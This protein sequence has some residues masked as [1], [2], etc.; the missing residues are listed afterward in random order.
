[1]EAAVEHGLE[2]LG[3]MAESASI[4]PEDLRSVATRLTDPERDHLVV[5]AGW[6]PWIRRRARN[7]LDGGGHCDCS[8]HISDAVSVYVG[9]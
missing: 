9:D 6:R 2:V 4:D 5:S 7:W 1:M 3:V 8:C